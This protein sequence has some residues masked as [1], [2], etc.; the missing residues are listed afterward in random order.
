VF[1]D[2]ADDLPVEVA[3]APAPEQVEQA[4]VVAR[5]EQRE[6]LAPGRVGEA[7]LH[8]ERPPDPL[9][10][11]ALQ[12]LA[13]RLE[14]L[15]QELRPHEEAPA[16][17]V[18]RVLVGAEDVGPA[19]RQEAGGGGDDP[20]PVEARGQEPADS[21]WP[22]GGVRGRQRCATEVTCGR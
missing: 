2:D 18:G 13:A 3:A 5:R 11:R 14:P 9:G 12:L 19:L 17:R 7:P 10:E 22:T 16:L 15:E 6:P 1:G 4:V 8:R 20:V 21:T